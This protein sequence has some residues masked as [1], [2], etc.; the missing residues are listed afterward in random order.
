MYPTT[1]FVIVIGGENDKKDS[2]D[3][4]E[5]EET[6]AHEYFWAKYIKRF[7]Y[8]LLLTETMF[9]LQRQTMLLCMVCFSLVQC[10]KYNV[11]YYKDGRIHGLGNFGMG[12]RIHAELAPS[13]SKMIDMIAYDGVDI[14]NECFKE[15]VYGNSVLDLCCGVGLST[16]STSLN[17]LNRGIDI[18]K[19]MVNKAKSM[20][21]NKQFFIG[22]AENY[23]PENF[24]LFDVT[25]CYF[26][27]HEMPKEAML[28][29][30]E[31]AKQITKKKIII[32]DIAPNYIPPSTMLAGE[33]YLLDYLHKIRHTLGDFYEKPIIK[34]RVHMWTYYI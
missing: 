13:I 17:A 12:G 16:P 5:R 1:F 34:N 6:T 8:G 15:Y 24:T 29:I 18:S 30:I 25:T 26:S 11:P 27:F 20:K 4:L 7:S 3:F 22:N 9:I 28:S 2:S 10:L 32:V 14:R 23:T 19:F 31:N 33:P 21:N